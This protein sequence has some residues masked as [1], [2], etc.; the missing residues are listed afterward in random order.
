M[1]GPHTFDPGHVPPHPSEQV[2]PI[3]VLLAQEQSGGLVPGHVPPHPSEQVSPVHVLLAQVQ[4]GALAP[5]QIAP[6]TPVKV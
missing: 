3:H 6:H 2:P 4:S 1:I 5:G